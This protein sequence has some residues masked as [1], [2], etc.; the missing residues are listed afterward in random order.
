MKLTRKNLNALPPL[1]TDG[2]WGTEMAKLGA[3][4][5]QMCDEWNVSEPEKVFS[6]AKSYVDAGAQ[7][8]LT[9]TFNSNRFVLA[10][11]GMAERAAEFSKAGAEISKRAAQSRAYVFASIGPC[12]KMVM[13][14]E[15]SPE[16]VEEMA[17][18]Q[19][20]ALAD[21]GADAI[22]VETQTDLVEAEA[23]LR[24]CL[25]ACDLSVGVSFT[26]DAGANNDHTMMGASVAEAYALAKAG[27]ASFVGANCG[28]GI[29]TFANIAEQFA[30]CGKELP[31]W[32]KG[33]AGK[34]E[35]GAD[36]KV[37]YHA[38]P[39]LYQSSVAP[40]LAAGARFIGGCCG[41]SPEHIRVVAATMRGNG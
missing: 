21:G 28:A 3:Q 10:K 40:L 25:R 39:E 36:G 23:A 35:L 26:F 5:G 9:N 20:A 33:N 4:P 34:A 12:G 2:A 30:A 22:V 19:A 18:E 14:G 13:M 1:C 6:V 29:E 8:I 11:H 32:I 41:S 31:I 17:A 27:G 15:A 37:R 16:E 7:I 38:G 24:G